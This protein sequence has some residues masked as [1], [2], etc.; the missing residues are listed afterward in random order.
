MN[1]K[2]IIAISIGSVLVVGGVALVLY[3][4]LFAEEPDE[5]FDNMRNRFPFGEREPEQTDS[6][7]PDDEGSNDETE[8]RDDKASTAS[9]RKLSEH[10]VVE[11]GVVS[12]EKREEPHIRYISKGEGKL[13]E[14]NVSNGEHQQIL[15][16]D[17]DLFSGAYKVSWMNKDNVLIFSHN[18]ESS[19]SQVVA[20]EFSED[21]EGLTWEGA[22]LPEKT[23]DASSYPDGNSFFYI[24]EKD[25]GVNGFTSSFGETS[26]VSGEHL[27]SSPIRDWLTEW[28]S[29]NIITL[30]TKPSGHTEGHMYVLNT[31]TG[32]LTHPL[33]GI[34]GLTT[35]TSQDASRT[36]YDQSQNN[37]TSLKLYDHEA[38]SSEEISD[39]RTLTDKCTFIDE[40]SFICAEPKDIPTSHVYPDAWY[41]GK[42][43]FEDEAFKLVNTDTKDLEEI[44][45]PNDISRHFDELDA[46][47]LS[48]DEERGDL[49]FT[50]KKTGMLW[51]YEMEDEE[52]TEESDED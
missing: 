42:V 8:N 37:S 39:I 41:Q 10:P 3:L 52:N 11:G 45:T 17:E 9:I 12:Y 24:S 18:E 43:S 1:K 30:T 13:Y 5:A 7:I 38:G 14:V 35:K 22:Q 20:V 50:N 46:Y 49:Y 28:P 16:N 27:F 23:V 19:D 47:D 44:V 32:S 48:F 33:R 26:T 15:G 51:V 34:A 40:K 6:D 29:G 31:Q 4:F 2:A 21:E 25:I 36:I